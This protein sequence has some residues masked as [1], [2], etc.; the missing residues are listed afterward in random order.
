MLYIIEFKSFQLKVYYYDSNKIIGHEVLKIFQSQGLM[1]QAHA[2]QGSLNQAHANQGS[3]NQAI[4]TKLAAK[5]KYMPNK[6]N[7]SMGYLH[8]M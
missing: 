3:L 8:L 7:A 2:N 5:V 1:N 6:G 4:T